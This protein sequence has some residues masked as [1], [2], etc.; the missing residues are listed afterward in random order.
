MVRW[1]VSVCLGTVGNCLSVYV[2]FHCPKMRHL[3]S[4]YYLSALAISDTIFLLTIFMV[5]LRFFEIDLFNN[6]G[7]CQALIYI[8]GVCSFL[9]VWLVVSFT[10]ERFIAVRYPLNQRSVW[11]VTRAKL[12]ISSL[13]IFGVIL[14]IPLVYLSAITDHSG[15]RVCGIEPE[16][17][18]LATKFNYVDTF[19]TYVAPVTII[20]F[21]NMWIGRII[22]HFTKIRREMT[23]RGN[24][25]G[26]ASDSLKLKYA[27]TISQKSITKMLLLVSTVFLCFNF[28]SYILRIVAYMIEV[29]AITVRYSY[30]LQQLQQWCQLLFYTNFG[31]N[32]ILYCASGKNFRRALK[33][34]LRIKKQQRTG[35][36]EVIV[37]TDSR[38]QSSGSSLASIRRKL[39]IL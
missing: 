7:T 1:L 18:D 39:N 2:F 15:T 33:K 32:F 16:L 38:V 31:I 23:L 35:R 4:S 12:V 24:R 13:V 20:L 29:K 27:N 22:F 10:M 37:L 3:S 6:E 28:P 14:Y 19:V 30:I 5:W 34:L 26:K 8:S 25:F 21:L 9:S 11:T 17:A 36:S